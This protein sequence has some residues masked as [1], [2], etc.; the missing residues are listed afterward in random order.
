MT[1]FGVVTGLAVEARLIE[2]AFVREP[3]AA[4]ALIC[5]GPGPERARAAAARLAAAGADTLVSFGLCGG[6][7]PALTVAERCRR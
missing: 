3:R 4:P 6:L 5:A 7:D 1:R 2:K